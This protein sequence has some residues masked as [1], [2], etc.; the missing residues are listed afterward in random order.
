MGL[1]TKI[2]GD[3][4]QKFIQKAR[5]VVGQVNS[6]EK[7]FEQLSSQQLK[8]KTSDFKNRLTQG[9]DLDGILPEAFAL[10]RESAKRTLKQRHFDVQLIGSLAL[11]QNKIAEMKT[12]EGKTLSATPAIFLNAL[13]GQGVHVVTVN[14][15]LAKRDAVWMGQIF[16][17]LGLTVGCITNQASYLYQPQLEDLDL[18]QKR[19]LVGNF[20]IEDSFLKQCS[21]AESYAADITYGTNNEYGFDYLRDNLVFNK[22]EMVQRGFNFAVIDEVDSI[23]IDEARTPLIISQ[24]DEESSKMY[25]DFSKITPA[26]KENADFNIDEKMRVVTLTEEGITKVEKMLGVENIYTDKG[27]NFVHHLEEALKAQFIFHKDRDYIVKD[28][29]ILI[30][31][32]F[33]GRILPDRRYS[34]GLHQALEA[35]EKVQVQ[36]ESKTLATITFQ[37]YFRFYRKLAGMTGTALTSAEEFDKVYKLGVVSVPTNKENIREDLSD[38]VYKNE[39]AKTRAIVRDI[40]LRHEK[41]Q[42]VLVG[43][44]SIEKNERLARFLKRE[45]IPHEILNAKQHEREAQIIAQAG[46]YGQVTVATN[47]AG[48]GVDIILGGNPPNQ[49]DAELVKTAGG[50]H[51]IGTERHEARRI[52]NQLRGRTA[53]QG[54]PGSSQFFISLSDDLLRVFGG[55]RIKSMMDLLKLEEDQPISAG[56]LSGAIERAQEKVEGL[57]FD[58]RKH[59]LDYDDV[60]S[61]HRGRIYLLRKEV[62]D[63]DFEGLKEL[64]LETVEKELERVASFHITEIINYEEI[65]EDV[66]SIFPTTAEFRDKL[67]KLQEKEEIVDLLYKEAEIA[68]GSKLEKEGQENLHKIITFVF[69]KTIDVFWT[70]H[71]E[72]LEHL[73]DS[74]RLRAYGGRDPLVEYKTE[75]HRLFNETLVAM[76]SQISRTFFKIVIKGA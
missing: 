23:L 67:G 24:P 19:D 61:K 55:D 39:E 37:N 53:R 65:A 63:R 36:A 59:I 72:A 60:V 49:E 21:R 50:L 32:E 64:I 15:Y 7:D 38:I 10:V 52:D 3:P 34:G 68:F 13:S 66:R 33:T 57:N 58:L 47:M 45:G 25:G 22:S 51:V 71:L 70:E 6:L 76:E 27:I 30:V 16:Q 14:D 73:R 17:A 18:D 46:R 8:D 44:T 26:L 35:K 48:R 40:K 2:F 74:V 12:G 43:T 54:D 5:L 42:P 62:L 29:K 69:L 41:G 1:L 31:D 56:I 20:K 11:H 75:S 28:G 4:N 9:E